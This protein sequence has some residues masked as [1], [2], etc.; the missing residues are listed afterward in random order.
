MRPALLAW[1]LSALTVASVAASPNDF[2][3]AKAELLAEEAVQGE[4]PADTKEAVDYTIFNDI[5]VPPM[6]DI[7]GDEFADTIKD[8]YW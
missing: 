3:P 8:G 7:P 4:T 2:E 6:K 5:K 1:V